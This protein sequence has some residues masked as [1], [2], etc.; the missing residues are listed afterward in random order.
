MSRLT[1]EDFSGYRDKGSK[2]VMLTAYD[3]PSALILDKAG[4]DIALIGDSVGTNVL[5]YSGVSEVTMADMIH[6]TGA[7][8]RG[9]ER[10][11][12]L[13]DM[14]YRSFE[15]EGAAVENA[16]LL[17]EAGADAVKIEGESE[18]T[19]EIIEAVKKAGID[20]CGHVGYTPQTQRGTVKVQ[21]KDL[22]RAKEL[23]E[24][25]RRL[26]RAGA[27]MTVLELMPKELSGIITES[28]DI[29]TIGIGGGVLCDGQ[30]QVIHD[31]TGFSEKV[32]RH[33]KVFADSGKTFS[34]AVKGYRDAVVSGSFPSD[35]NSSRLGE[36]T[37][38][39]LKESFQQ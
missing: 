38:S 4:V 13:T 2:I 34:E 6:H 39:R 29:P 35:K 20:V 28:V 19:F 25:V 1:P 32:F 27:F 11:M 26:K 21:G 17:I 10:A 15:T 22:Q 3:Y 36:E 8:S 18:S 24:S 31:I 16:S 12:V 14:P 9:V 5:G 23:I 37:L 7:V 33:S 30:V